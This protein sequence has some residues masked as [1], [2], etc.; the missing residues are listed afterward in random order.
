MTDRKSVFTPFVKQCLVAAAVSINMVGCG[1]FFGFPGI[2]L[3]QLQ[4][5][6]L[7]SMTVNQASWLASVGSIPMIFGNFLVPPIMTY[8]G[9]KKAIY[10]VILILIVS[11]F[12]LCLATS[13][14]WL[15]IGRMLQGFSFGMFM[16]LRSIYIGEC[17]SPRYRAGF[18]STTSLAMALGLC[19]VHLTGSLLTYQITALCCLSFPFISLLIMIY[20][21]ESPSWLATRG[22]YDKCRNNFIWLRG[23]E[24]VSEIDKLIEKLKLLDEQQNDQKNKFRQ[25][26]TVVKKKEFFKPVLLMSALFIMQTCSGGAIMG[27]YAVTVLGLLM[28]PEVNVHFCMVAFDF[29]RLFAGCAAI[30]LINKVRRRRMLFVMGVL[31]GGSQLLIGAYVFAK[32]K[33]Y[34]PFDSL[35]I[36]GVLVSVQMMTVSLGMQPLP[37]VIAGEVFP[38]QHKGL[39][40][41]IGLVTQCLSTLMVLK[42]FPGLVSSLSLEGT[43]A[44]CSGVIA[45]CLAV[46]WMLLPETSGKTL[47]QIEDHFKGTLISN[48][49]ARELTPLNKKLNGVDI[50]DTALTY[51]VDNVREKEPLK[52][53][54]EELSNGKSVHS[55]CK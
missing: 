3:P 4:S 27:V 54:Y 37:A 46:A 17:C 40:G 2:L 20:S 12:T 1:A 18:L 28:G 5:G 25:V 7:I 48:P 42:T 21:P 13:Y 43:Y 35:W 52:E 32:T 34:L 39:A 49:E 31:N 24:E 51:T 36:P 55:K 14:E 53:L 19:F 9:R 45:S 38:L 6:S 26:I 30:Y 44:V 29:V 16:P 41:S 47:Q 10:C 15:L 8:A 23:K 11:W 22:K 33:G 50:Q